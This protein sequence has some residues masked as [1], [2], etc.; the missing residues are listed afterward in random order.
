MPD[1]AAANAM[2]LLKDLEHEAQAFGFETSVGS[3][4]DLSDLPGWM[5]AALCP[6]LLIDAGDGLKLAIL[7]HRGYINAVEIHGNTYT[8]NEPPPV[9]ATAVGLASIASI[10][11]KWIADHASSADRPR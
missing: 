11:R 3:T 10:A 5:L 2:T 8:G 9:E 7:L 6:A 4:R 1:S